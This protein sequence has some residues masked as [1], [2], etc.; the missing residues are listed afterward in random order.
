MRGK[1]PKIPTLG[2][3]GIWDPGGETTLLSSLLPVVANERWILSSLPL[4]LGVQVV[5][6]VN[7]SILLFNDLKFYRRRGAVSDG[8]E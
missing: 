2:E 1:I 5:D 8:R 6:S 7:P 3:T 4:A